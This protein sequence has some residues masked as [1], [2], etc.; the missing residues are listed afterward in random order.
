VLV[1]IFDV[2]AEFKAGQ[3]GAV[4]IIAGYGSVP[5]RVM[6]KA[7][8]D[9]QAKVYA[10][11][12]QLRV[13]P[14]GSFDHGIAL[15]LDLTYLQ[16]SGSGSGTIS[17]DVAPPMPYD[18][19]A[20]GSGFKIGPFAGYKLVLPVG[21]TFRAELGIEYLSAKALAK[22]TS[23]ASKSASKKMP[24]VLLDAGVGWSF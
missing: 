8:P 7:L 15:G 4:A 5:L 22:D 17:S 24:L 11:G 14:I 3:R 18:V 12:G 20:S 9:E 21:L 6:D 13:Y 2:T 19:T 1:S 10:V 16:G 23:G